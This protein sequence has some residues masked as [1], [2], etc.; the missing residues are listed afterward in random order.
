MPFSP[1]AAVWGQIGRAWTTAMRTSPTTET[2]SMSEHVA[3]FC[4]YLG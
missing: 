1:A 3:F 2:I 4:Q